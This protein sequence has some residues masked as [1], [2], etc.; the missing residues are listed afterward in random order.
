MFVD[1]L[2]KWFSLGSNDEEECID[3]ALYYQLLDLNC[4]A[5]AFYLQEGGLVGANSRFL[6]CFGLDSLDA[7]NARYGSLRAL[8]EREEDVLLSENDTVWLEYVR[9]NHPK[10]YGVEFKGVNGERRR[11][12]MV[13]SKLPKEE[14]E[15]YYLTF[16]EA[17]EIDALQLRL[18]QSDAGKQAFLSEVG[19]QFRTPMQGI[20][21]FVKM[22]ESS[23]MDETQSSYLRQVSQS[24]RELV[25]NIE[26]ILDT[27]ELETLQ[28][29]KLM[30]A[31]FHPQVE[32]ENLLNVFV[33]K[34]MSCGATLSGEVDPLLPS[35]LR[36]DIKRLKQLLFSVLTYAIQVSRPRSE[37]ILSLKV[38]ERTQERV[39]V[40]FGMLITQ[41]IADPARD[42]MRL[43]STLI[44]LLGGSLTIKSSDEGRAALAFELSFEIEQPVKLSSEQVKRRRALVV[45]D[46]RINQNLMR[47]MLEG[48]EIDVTLAD[49]GEEAVELAAK[50][51][52][53]IIFMDI[54][55]PIK[56]GIE[57]TKQIKAKRPREARF[58]PIVAVTALAMQADEQRL[59]E[60][61]LDDY[62]AKPLTREML[63]LVLEKYL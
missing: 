9:R 1:W 3:K 20:L 24:A 17:D 36:G 13:V 21:G 54:D 11:L 40:G 27:A 5:I 49:N 38:H 25:T 57:A 6:S 8:F 12:L 44:S 56:N 34:A 60:A 62:M 47:L 32:I 61:G 16:K 37:L 4:D 22:L 29:P 59:L 23:P 30:I 39:S 48:Y 63:R 50:K 2:R 35:V 58:V 15:L 14:K 42:D 43:I 51:E 52:F 53:D 18:M 41:T 31:R 55:M 45:E 7:F 28:E 26:N 19:M 10:G 33:P 46:N